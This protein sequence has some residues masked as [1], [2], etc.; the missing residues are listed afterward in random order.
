MTLDILHSHYAI[1]SGHLIEDLQARMG[2][3]TSSKELCTVAILNDD[4]VC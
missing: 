1:L 3:L 4:L 2:S